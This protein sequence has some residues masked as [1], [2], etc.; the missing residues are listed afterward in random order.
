MPGKR[1]GNSHDDSN[2]FHKKNTI[3]TILEFADHRNSARM[4]KKYCHSSLHERLQGCQQRTDCRIKVKALS[5][6]RIMAV[7]VLVEKTHDFL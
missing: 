3:T 7:K 4:R 2:C 6:A 5:T 1:T